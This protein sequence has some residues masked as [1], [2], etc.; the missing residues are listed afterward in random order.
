MLLFFFQ[1]PTSAKHCTMGNASPRFCSQG[2][3]HL[4]SLA[5]INFH[6]AF[7]ELELAGTPRGVEF[8][9]SSSS[10]KGDQSWGGQL[11]AS[12]QQQGEE[13]KPPSRAQRLK[14]LGTNYTF[15]QAPGLGSLLSKAR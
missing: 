12:K 7:S 9:V 8:G 13:P 14:D 2:A 6:L 5:R 11:G 3:F 4:S 1:E 15:R 10:R